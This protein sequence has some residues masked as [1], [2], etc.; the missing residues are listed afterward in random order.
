MQYQLL[1]LSKP[2]SAIRTQPKTKKVSAQ[3]RQQIAKKSRPTPATLRKPDSIKLGEAAITIERLNVQIS[4]LAK[5]GLFVLVETHGASMFSMSV[6]LL[7]LGVPEESKRAQSGRFRSTMYDLIDPEV[8]KGMRNLLDR[9]RYLIDSK[10]G[11]DVR[12]CSPIS[13]LSA[14]RQLRH[15]TNW[16]IRELS[17]ATWISSSLKSKCCSTS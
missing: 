11:V 5:R 9:A 3:I 13:P 15:W 7:E 6:N 12:I 10:F 16:A 8:R 14:L 2:P 17:P 4:Q 1:Q